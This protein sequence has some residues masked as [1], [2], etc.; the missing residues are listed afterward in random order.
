MG[1][2][3]RGLLIAAGVLLLIV[4][5]GPFLVPVPPL[6]DTVPARE[7]AGPD[8][9]FVTVPFPGTDGIDV[10]VREMGQGERTLVL[11]HGFASNVYTWDLV[12]AD[13]ARHGRVIAYD[14]PAFGLTERPMP[15]EWNG[16]NPYSTEASDEISIALFDALG[17]ERAVLVGNSAGGTQAVRLALA[18]PER[19]EALVLVDP[20]IYSGGGTPPFVALIANT[21]QMD[22]LGPLVSRFFVSL[23]ARL[24]A[25][26]YHDPSR[27]TAEQRE[28]ASIGFR[29]DNWDRAF[30]EFT[31]ASQPA[32]LPARLGELTL[33]VLVITG[34]DDRI[35]PTEESIRL[36]GE[37]PDAELAIIPA[38]G[39][40]PQLECPQEFMVAVDGFL[41]MLE[42]TEAP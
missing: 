35:V 24:E 27:I 9:R 3:G 23:G 30:W 7:L 18:Y 1:K 12:M 19:V 41:S 2:V 32:D 37:L 20:A 21:P 4:L 29:V 14:R 15:G 36:A 8:S 28:L 34:D 11:L 42:G 16:P 5:V 17:V 33:H 39:H 25:Q 40:T 6:E 10:H 13:M 38:C 31:A 26:S 22:R